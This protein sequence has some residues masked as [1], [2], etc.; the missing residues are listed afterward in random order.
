VSAAGRDDAG[1]LSNS[2]SQKVRENARKWMKAD[3]NEIVFICFLLF[4][5]I[6]T[7]QRLAADSSKKKILAPGALAS[8]FEF[9][10]SP[11][12]AV[13]MAG[14]VERGHHAIRFQSCPNT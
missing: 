6:G 3:E 12:A 9:L 2:G 4:F 10:Q 13:L 11:M 8:I 1:R 7:F 14:R 5:G